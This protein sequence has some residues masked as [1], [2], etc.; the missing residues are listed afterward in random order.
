VRVREVPQNLI[1]S[2]IEAV[3]CGG[4]SGTNR[5]RLVLI[6]SV[7][8]KDRSTFRHLEQVVFS[9]S[10]CWR[11]SGSEGHVPAHLQYGIS[12]ER[13]D[14][15]RNCILVV[16]FVLMGRDGFLNMATTT[17]TRSQLNYPSL[18]DI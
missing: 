7:P 12:A 5:R 9:T 8:N 1:R 15:A 10:D 11:P 16:T 17:E 3:A 2:L 14:Q 6:L 13:K 4:T 18:H